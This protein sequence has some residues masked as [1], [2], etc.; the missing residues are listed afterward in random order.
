MC[1]D[2]DLQHYAIDVRNAAREICCGDA[3][4]ASK[5][6]DCCTHDGLV[7]FMHDFENYCADERRRQIEVMLAGCFRQRKA[8]SMSVSG[9]IINRWDTELADMIPW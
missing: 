6:L 9:D 7:A 3:E 8:K 4:L 5:L 2:H 1:K